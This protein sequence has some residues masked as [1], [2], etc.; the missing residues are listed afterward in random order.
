MKFYPAIDLVGG[1]PVRLEQG[2]FSRSTAYE[3]APEAAVEEFAAQGADMI[4]VVDLDGAR[5]GRPCQHALIMRMAEKA[6]VQAAGGFRKE[7]H[8]AQM[9][10][11][12]AARVV[13]GSLALTDSD[14]FSRLLERFGPDRITLAIDVHVRAGVP[15]VATHGW[16]KSSDIPLS[17]LLSRFPIVRHLL[18]TDIDKDGMMRGPNTELMKTILVEHPQVAL[19]ASG[20]VGSLDHLDELREAGADGVIVGKAIWD[21]VFTV[22]EGCARARG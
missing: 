15:E 9:L 1:R 2:D 16:V 11:S 3:R 13:I 6:P 20:G 12:G 7:A 8:V 19:Q 14:A 4:H 21:G 22:A 10:D 18:V 17:D 5:I